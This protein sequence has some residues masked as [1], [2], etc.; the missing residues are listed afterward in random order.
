MSSYEIEKEEP[1]KSRIVRF[2]NLLQQAPKLESISKEQF[3]ELQNIIV[4]PRFKDTDYRHTQNYVG[5]NISPY[6]QKIHYISPKPGDVSE[7]M[8]GLLDS[9]DRSLKSHVNPVIIAAAISFGFVFIHPF[10]DGN[11]R[12]HRF[13]IHYILSRTKFTPPNMIFPVS[14]VMLHDL[15][16]YDAVLEVF[17]KPLLSKLTEYH[18]SDDGVMIVKQKTKHFINILILLLWRKILI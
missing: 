15:S 8:H 14:S 3:I 10:E 6:M 2:I 4:D 18:L 9:L 11:G 5:E 13:L 7:L 16:S 17:S 12:I 1:S